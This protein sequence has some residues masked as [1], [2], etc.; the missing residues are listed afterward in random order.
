MAMNEA[1][2]FQCPNCGSPLTA[3]G[4]EAEIKCPY[5]GSSVIVPA[6]LRRKTPPAASSFPTPPVYT[7]P[8][9]FPQV[10]DQVSQTISTAGKVAAG[11]AISSMIAPIAITLVVFCVVGVF[12][13]FLFFGINQTFSSVSQLVDPHAL[14]TSIVSTMMPAF[15]EG[16]TDIPATAAPTETPTPTA[17]PIAV[18]TPFSRVLLHDTFV[19]KKGWGSLNDSGYILAYVKGG[20]RVFIDGDGGQT[21]WLDNLSYKDVNVAAD[22][23][24]VAGPDDGIFSVSCRVKNGAGFYSFEFSPNGWYGIEKYTISGNNSNADALAEGTIDTSGFD[25]T[26]L[27]H[28][29]G[30]CVGDTLT[31]YMNGQPVAQATDTSFTSGSIGLGAKLGPS[32]DLGVDVLFSNY[33]VTGK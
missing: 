14:Q 32:G 25:K 30:D 5:C 31:L 27:Y 15:T 19:T 12:L 20:Y 21:T 1:K 17:T 16:P 13:A 29:R 18:A 11:I 3:P 8:Q 22:L 2:K 10:D 7:F 26:A 28:L 9:G 6:E 23:K 33:T 4:G 24:Y